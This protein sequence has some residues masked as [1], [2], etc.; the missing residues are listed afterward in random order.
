MT[1][2]ETP[3]KKK[4]NF[5]L[6]LQRISLA[7][8][9]TCILGFISSSVRQVVFFFYLQGLNL[10]TFESEWVRSVKGQTGVFV[11]LSS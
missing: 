4:T 5:L 1:Q 2:K 11:A 6:V 7:A 3:L 8:F 10:S 9:F